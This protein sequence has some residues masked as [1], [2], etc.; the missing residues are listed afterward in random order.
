[1][2]RNKSAEI[3]TE[4]C[5]REDARE[6][7]Q[8]NLNWRQSGLPRRVLMYSHGRPMVEIA[9]R[10][11]PKLQLLTGDAPWHCCIIDNFAGKDRVNNL[12]V[13]DRI[14][15]DFK[16]VPIQDDHVGGL[17]FLNAAELILFSH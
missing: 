1:M 2:L 15:V 13:N 11:A 14:R 6:H 4:Q 12:G 3:H 8:R 7:D 5:A 9:A 17:A 10:T 16:E